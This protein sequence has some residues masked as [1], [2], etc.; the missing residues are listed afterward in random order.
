MH[1]AYSEIGWGVPFAWAAIW[2]GISVV[3]V[4]RDLFLEAEEWEVDSSVF[5]EKQEPELKEPENE[6]V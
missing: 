2:T 1:Q 3:W 5:S 6:P 4:R